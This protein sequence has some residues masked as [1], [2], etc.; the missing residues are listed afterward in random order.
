MGMMM[1]NDQERN[2]D[3]NRRITADLRNKLQS[4]DREAPDL[5]EDAAYL[6]DTEKTGK[7]SW[8]WIVLVVLAIIS[9]FCILF[10]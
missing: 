5:A 8:I 10:I 4:A 6:K 1:T 3:L 2:T 9:L 7:H